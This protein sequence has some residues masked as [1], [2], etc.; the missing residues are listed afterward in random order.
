MNRERTSTSASPD[1]V[2]AVG[3]TVT[4]L[5]VLDN[6]VAPWAPFHLSHALAATAIPFA[7]GGLR[8]LAPGELRSFGR[9][10]LA[11]LGPFV[12]Q[13]AATGLLVGW[14]PLLAALGANVSDP[15]AVSFPAA[16]PA[17]FEAGAARL[18]RAPGDV[19]FAYLGFVTLWA[20]FGEEFFYRGF[21]QR[22]LAARL[23]F[24]AALVLSSLLFGV[25]H[26]AQLALLRPFPTIAALEWS[27]VAFLLGLVFG[28][29]YRRTGSL[30]VPIVLHTLFNAIPIVSYLLAAGG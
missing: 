30:F 15:V 23:P 27:L 6:T 13:A 2:L 28:V 1:A 26:G 29:I 14:V 4:A 20:G 25:R 22:H 21:L 19:A 5:A 8:F 16:L 9:W 12:L 7:F 10:T 3:V 17:V 24:G 11:L 18:G